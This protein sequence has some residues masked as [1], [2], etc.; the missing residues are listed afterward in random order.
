MRYH[1]L[2]ILKIRK[3]VTKFVVCCSRDCRLRV[4]LYF[5]LYPVLTR[6]KKLNNN[7]LDSHIGES[8]EGTRRPDTPTPKEKYKCYRFPYGKDPVGN[9]W[10]PL[11]IIVSHFSVE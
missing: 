8:R 4:S 11:K 10:T 3:D 1:T 7:N 2:F 6:E 9:A 5:V